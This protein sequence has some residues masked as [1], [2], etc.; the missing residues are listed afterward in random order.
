MAR[1]QRASGT[2]AHRGVAAA[3]GAAGTIAI[4]L[5]ILN[6]PAHAQD[7]R[8]VQALT[9][10]IER[11]QG[12]LNDLQRKVYG[13]EMPETT[14][15]T[16]GDTSQTGATDAMTQAAGRRLRERMGALESDLRRLTGQLQETRHQLREATKRLDK[17]VKDVDYRLRELEEFQT[18]AAKQLKAL[19]TDGATGDQT[20]RADDGGRGDGAQPASGGDT[21]GQMTASAGTANGDAAADTEAGEA[22]DR[23]ADPDG[24]Q[25]ANSGGSGTIGTV[26]KDAVDQLRQEAEQSAKQTAGNDEEKP[27][28]TQ[29]AG[30]TQ[31]ASKPSGSGVLPD[32]RPQAQYDHAFKLLSDRDYAKAEK[33]LRAFVEAHPKHKLAGNAQDW[34]GETHYVRENYNQAAVVFAEG[35]RTYPDSRKAPANLLKLGITLAKIDKVDKACRLFSELQK[36]F[37]DAAQNIRHRAQREEKRLGCTSGS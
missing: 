21:P 16:G 7:G 24:S 10:K 8:E 1:N 9:Q 11:L 26:S 2:P 32:A 28:S 37:P 25:G 3:I 14:S 31:T 17:L 20:A 30:N 22:G 34:L 36:R 29:A 33:A 6:A 19:T 18:R 35:F 4:L 15:G 12:E 23:D 27:D 13:G 5:A